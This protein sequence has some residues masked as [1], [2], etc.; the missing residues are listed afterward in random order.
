MD[1]NLEILHNRYATALYEVAEDSKVVDRVMCELE[2]LN[3]LWLSDSNFRTFLTHPFITPEEKKAVIGKIIE[4]KKCCESI[5]NFVRLLIDQNR[6]GFIHGVFLAY[7]DIYELKQNKIRM[8]VETPK[9]LSADE[10]SKLK[11]A[12]KAKFKRDIFLEEY[13]NPE[14][15]A[16]LHVRYR[17]RIFDNSI[18]SNLN[19]LREAIV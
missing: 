1:E 8:V 17:D 14:I 5:L 11:K 16:G 9:S 3:D 12:L 4:E 19:K 7:R 2:A 10:N 13:I 15:I 18:R 6:D